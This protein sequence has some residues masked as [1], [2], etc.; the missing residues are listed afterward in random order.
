MTS[1]P[2]PAAL[3]IPQRDTVV[4]RGSEVRPHRQPD[5]VDGAR[6][7]RASEYGLLVTKEPAGYP[8]AAELQG[9][10]EDH[11]ATMVTGGLDV[12]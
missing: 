7:E 11:K 6:P 9:S 1:G 4:G 12:R 2:G 3:P 5:G 8:A 10:G